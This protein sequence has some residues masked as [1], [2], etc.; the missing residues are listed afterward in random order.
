[1]KG[2]LLTEKTSYFLLFWFPA[3]QDAQMFFGEK[4]KKKKEMGKKKKD[5]WHWS[6]EEINRVTSLHSWGLIEGF[7]LLKIE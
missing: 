1:M 3:G 2:A 7:L 4:I 6:T 5:R